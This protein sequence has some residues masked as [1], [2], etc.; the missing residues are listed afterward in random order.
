[1]KITAV[2]HLSGARHGATHFITMTTFNPLYCLRRIITFIPSQQIKIVKFGKVKQLAWSNTV[3]IRPQVSGTPEAKLLCFPFEHVS[4]GTLFNQLHIIAAYNIRVA[5]F[6][7]SQAWQFIDEATVPER[8]RP[9]S[10]TLSGAVFIV[11]YVCSLCYAEIAR[12]TGWG[13]SSQ[14]NLFLGEG[15]E[16][17]SRLC[18]PGLTSLLC[19][20][21]MSDIVGIISCIWEVT[22]IPRGSNITSEK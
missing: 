22:S 20:S 9:R 15:L 11:H 21:T 16:E 1:M 3:R 12:L 14:T 18:F 7:N 6:C 13:K 8:L 17:E 19:S 2:N 4:F 5:E 10:H